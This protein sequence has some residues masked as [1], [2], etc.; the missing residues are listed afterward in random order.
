MI[1]MRVGQRR[2][3]KY[4]GLPGKELEIYESDREGIRDIRVCQGR[5]YNYESLLGKKYESMTAQ[6]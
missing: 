5:N 6:E 4:E 1:N 2:N 3:D